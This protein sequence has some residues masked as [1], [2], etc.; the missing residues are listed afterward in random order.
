MIR[1]AKL[2][3]LVSAALLL[4]QYNLFS[5]LFPIE[6]SSALLEFHRPGVQETSRNPPFSENSITESLMV[7]ARGPF[8]GRSGL[9]QS[10]R[11]PCLPQ[12]H[13]PPT[14][15][16]NLATEYFMLRF[17][18]GAN[19]LA[20][21]SSILSNFNRKC[22][23]NCFPLVHV[24]LGR[25]LGAART[26]FATST[27]MAALSLNLANGTPVP[28]PGFGA[29]TAWFDTAGNDPTRPRNKELISSIKSALQVGYRH[30]DAAEV[31]GTEYEVGI[32]MKESAVPREDIFLTTKVLT[33]ISDPVKAL[34]ES[35]K[36]LQVD[37]V[38]L[39]L[40]HYP[41][42]SKET[43]GIDLKEAWQAM[44]MVHERGMAKNIGVSNFRVVDLEK[45]LS[46]ANVKPAAN[47]IEFNPYLQ[48]RELVSFCHKHG[49]SVEAFSP[50]APIVRKLG[51]PL[52][53]VTEEIAKKY[54]KSPGQVLLRWTM[55]EGVIPV[56]TSGKESRQKEQL[57]I[58]SFELTEEEVERI[59]VAGSGLHYRK[60]F[61]KFF[62]NE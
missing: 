26:Q 9:L 25:S 47:Q 61:V 36:R 16:S 20:S 62:E 43:H 33:N 1:F 39:Y 4:L 29:G 46:F 8:L 13:P 18:R 56:T 52:D 48:S 27:T 45:V 2:P 35:L 40:I 15:L 37:Y 34:S 54:G 60:Y 30:L 51:G 17:A 7:L 44:E 5:S 22:S 50:L 59:R 19:F 32:A 42:F 41:F 49:I 53:P 38:D 28:I 11:L 21:F 57:A 6:V 12:F 24:P 10:H 3:I 23:R 31:Y 55:Q 58:D 14:N